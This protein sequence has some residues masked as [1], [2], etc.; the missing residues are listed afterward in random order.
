MSSWY[1][2]A[3]NGVN[4]DNFAS[5]RVRTYGVDYRNGRLVNV[6]DP[7][8]RV[9]PVKAKPQVP[10]EHSEKAMEFLATAISELE[11]LLPK[12]EICRK[13]QPPSMAAGEQV[14]H[15]VRQLKGVRDLL[16]LDSLSADQ[17]HRMY[18]RDY[19]DIAT[20]VQHIIE[21]GQVPVSS[22][23]D[24]PKFAAERAQ[25]AADRMFKMNLEANIA[26]K[27]KRD[28]EKAKVAE[29][30]RKRKE[31]AD[32]LGLNLGALPRG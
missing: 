22:I 6:G 21:T 7:P 1:S 17:L 4:E 5:L 8:A 27:K 2:D 24:S 28:E 18:L 31:L 26:R 23:F 10:A 3:S 16:Y 30:E 12:L 13:I 14:E 29:Q 32:A 9:K 19:P 20:V 11:P 15:L 25:E